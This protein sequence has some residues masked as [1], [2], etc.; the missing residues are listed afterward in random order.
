[1]KF[2]Q[3]PD[4]RFIRKAELAELRV[5]EVRGVIKMWDPDQVF[6]AMT[7]GPRKLAKRA[8]DV[9]AAMRKNHEVLIEGQIPAGVLV[10]VNE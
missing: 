2:T 7:N 10:E 5:L 3:A 1:R 8:A 6:G 4:N 9:R